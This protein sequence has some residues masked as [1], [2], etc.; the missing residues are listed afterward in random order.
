M[1]EF[2]VCLVQLAE[3]RVVAARMSWAASGPLSAQ[4]GRIL[5]DITPHSWQDAL[6]GRGPISEPPTT[7]SALPNQEHLTPP[8]EAAITEN[9][10]PPAL[11]LQITKQRKPRNLKGVCGRRPKL[12]GP[13]QCLTASVSCCVKTARPHAPAPVSARFM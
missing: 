3:S 4:G 1:P 9:G 10:H 5:L 12:S 11:M 2:G 6:R 7:G 8:G 13:R